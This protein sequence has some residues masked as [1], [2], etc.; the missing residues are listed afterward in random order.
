MNSYEMNETNDIYPI[1]IANVQIMYNESV[2]NGYSYVSSAAQA[3]IE[4]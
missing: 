2:I 4:D 1:N 3:A